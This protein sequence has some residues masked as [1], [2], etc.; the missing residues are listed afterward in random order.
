[1]IYKIFLMVFVP[2]V[3][4]L[5]APVAQAAVLYKLT[6]LGVFNNTLTSLHPIASRGIAIN[7][8]G[9]VV[10]SSDPNGCD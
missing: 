2:S 1:M 10:G 5:S 6:E 4:L 9:Q 8:N 3:F 7:N